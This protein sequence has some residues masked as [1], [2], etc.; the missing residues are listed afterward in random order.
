MK[1]LVILGLLATCALAVPA[2]NAHVVYVA[3]TDNDGDCD[4][5]VVG[6]RDLAPHAAAWSGDCGPVYHP[7]TL[8]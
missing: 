1:T 5:T 8:P 7:W 2:A 6:R 4:Y 3:D